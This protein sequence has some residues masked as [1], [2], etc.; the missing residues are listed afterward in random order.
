M[1]KWASRTTCNKCNVIQFN[2][3][4]ALFLLFLSKPLFSLRPYFIDSQKTE[5]SLQQLEEA[6]AGQQAEVGAQEVER[7]VDVEGVEGDGGDADAVGEADVHRVGPALGL[8]HGPR[9]HC[10]GRLPARL[11]AVGCNQATENVA[12]N[13]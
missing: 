1:I 12:C 9:H 10:T 3:A 8:G 4:Y 5:S 6:H 7:G 2:R 11:R 13:I